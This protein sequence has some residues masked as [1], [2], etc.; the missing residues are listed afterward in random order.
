MFSRSYLTT[1]IFALL[2]STTNGATSFPSTSHAQLGTNSTG[3]T[4]PW[5]QYKSSSLTP[6][7][8]NSTSNGKA[9]ADGYLF[10]GPNHV[11][12]VPNLKQSGAFILTSSG[13]LVY[14]NDREG[15]MGFRTQMYKGKPVLT[16]WNGATP[17]GV[18][19]GR[20][21]GTIE[22]LGQDYN[23][24]L[25]VN[26]TYRIN[27]IF[28][29]G[30]FDNHI[31]D[32]RESL[33]TPRNTML[34][35]GYNETQYDLTPI[36]GPKDGWITNNL[37]WE[38]DPVSQKIL[39]E[40]SAL[41]H[42]P[43][44]ASRQPLSIISVDG[45]GTRAAPWDYFHANSIDYVNGDYL[46]NARHLWSSILISGQDG[47]I[48]WKFEGETGGDFKLSPSDSSSHFRWEHH[49]NAHNIT[50]TSMDISFLNNAN[51]EETAQVNQT[52]AMVFHLDWSQKG[53]YTADLR[54][55]ILAGDAQKIY[56]GSQGSYQPTLSNGNQLVFYG[57]SAIVA[58]FGP[59]N[60]GSDL[61]WKGQFGF[62]NEIFSYRVFKN[63]WSATPASWNPSLVVE[64]GAAY[65]SWNGATDVDTWV[66]YCDAKN[67]GQATKKGFETMIDVSSLH[68]STMQVAAVTKGK[69]I[70]RSNT[71]T[72]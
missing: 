4:W 15:T 33:V 64:K 26:P 65:V 69:S 40:W 3:H 36:G 34:I 66:V 18:N 42:I 7:Q 62:L 17:H 39:F 45:N 63:K 19:D 46:V 6:P 47:C 52:T 2:S 72:I 29:E 38:I 31:V 11:A 25:T 61:R 22:M 49:A 23:S 13:D 48:K 8:L 37:I 51:H 16:F 54:R 9:L 68:C 43:I 20:Y 50:K 60:D 32:V 21:Y 67:V 14:G 10:L 70:R 1:A 44:T 55:H 58:E 35:I 53:S 27:K 71:V 5:Y 56:S 28:G 30:F 41:D 57:Q 59:G 24:V 12:G